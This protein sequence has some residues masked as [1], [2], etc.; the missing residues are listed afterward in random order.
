MTAPD[1]MRDPV[2]HELTERA[3]PGGSGPAVSVRNLSK[4]YQIYDRPQ[5]RLWQGLWRGKRHFFREFWALREVSFEVDKGETVGIIGRNGSGKSTLLQI[6]AGTMSPTAGEVVLRGRA[7]ALLELGSGFSPDFTGRENVYVN[8]SLLGLSS[9]EIGRRFGE[10]A[11]FAD[12]GDFIDQPVKT[13]S[14]GMLVRLAFSVAVSVE[15]EILIVDEALAV[16]DM[17]FQYKCMARLER[18]TKSGTTLLFVSHDIALVKAFCSRAVYLADGR[19]RASGSADAVTERY[20]L[21]VRDSQRAALGSTYPVE[22]K[23]FRGVGEGIAFGTTQ[24][25]IARAVFA[26]TGAVQSTF[27]AGEQ[28]RIRVDVEYDADLRGPLLSILVTDRR[29]VPVVGRQCALPAGEGSDKR[30]ESVLFAFPCVFMT[31]WYYVTLRLEDRVSG[32]YTTLI[33]KQVGVLS[34]QALRRGDDTFLG[35]VD[36]GIEATLAPPGAE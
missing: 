35:M 13:Y 36:I 29:T 7:A 34:F 24:G 25:R 11:A 10:I 33:E 4:C 16:G 28:I 2:S 19:V 9:D 1:A 21:D 23:P 27:S 22:P 3:D 18:L 32:T 6:I 15:P 20:T 17:A 8:G 26:D 12:I 5:D 14:S 31:D 30:H